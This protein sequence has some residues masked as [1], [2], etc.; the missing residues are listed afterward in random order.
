MEVS[1]A[2]KRGMTHLL[3]IYFSKEWS[4]FSHILEE[5]NLEVQ[6]NVHYNYKRSPL[7]SNYCLL[8]QWEN[9]K[10]KS[11]RENDSSCTKKLLTYSPQSS[12]NYHRPAGI[13]YQ[14]YQKKRNHYSIVLYLAKTF[15]KMKKLK[16]SRHAEVRTPYL[17]YKIFWNFFF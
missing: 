9:K 17:L 5:I 14:M 3:K 15:F 16:L 2:E 13:I 7:K 6:K 4:Y 10:V 8:Q 1:K 12:Q 11:E